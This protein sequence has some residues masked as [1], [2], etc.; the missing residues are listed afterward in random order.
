LSNQVS[1]IIH[2]GAGAGVT[3]IARKY[4]AHITDTLRSAARGMY[5]LDTKNFEEGKS[6]HIFVPIA[7]RQ[8]TFTIGTEQA[9]Y[10]LYR[11]GLTP[12]TLR[13]FS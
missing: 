5:E 1:N 10:I 7:P 3:R 13:Y 11:V 4:I 9:A 6:S 8:E 12:A 2:A